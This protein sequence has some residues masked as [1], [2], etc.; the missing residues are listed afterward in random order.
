LEQN[1]PSY[2]KKSVVQLPYMLSGMNCVCT[3]CTDNAEEKQSN[4]A[5]KRT[6]ALKMALPRTAHPKSTQARTAQ[7]RR[8]K[9]DQH[10]LQ[11]HPYYNTVTPI[12]TSCTILHEIFK[13]FL[14]NLILSICLPVKTESFCTEIK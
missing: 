10:S 2:K 6:H 4:P 14:F 9:P 11:S 1:P 5:Q 8:A 13:R 12:N 3:A 7:L